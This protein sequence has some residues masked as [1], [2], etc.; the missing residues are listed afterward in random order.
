[1]GGVVRTG[2]MLPLAVVC[3]LLFAALQP[4]LDAVPDLSPVM[5]EV[6]GVHPARAAEALREAYAPGGGFPDKY[7]PLAS[8]LMGLAGAVVD[9]AF[10]T[11]SADLARLG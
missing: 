1:M 2:R 5:P 7:P 9:P 8:A 11:D 6:D 3:G 4:A 10:G